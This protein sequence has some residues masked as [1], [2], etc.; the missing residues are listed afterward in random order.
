[1]IRLVLD[2][3]LTVNWCFD[4]GENY[5]QAVLATLAEGEA[6][7]PPDWP[8]EVASLLKRAVVRALLTQEDAQTFL[9]LLEGLPIRARAVPLSSTE[10][11][12][13]LTGQGLSRHQAAC[14]HLAHHGG[15]ILATLDPRLRRAAGQLGVALFEPPA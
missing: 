6:L 5:P 12:E 2:G 11:F 14:L 13:L 4:G 10:A 7:V 9:G 15:L 8:L 3:A 1:M